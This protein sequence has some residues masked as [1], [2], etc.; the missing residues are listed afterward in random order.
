M[1]IGGFLGIYI[2]GKET[3][4]Y[5]VELMLPIIIGVIGGL[6]VFLMISKWS[7][8]RRGNVPEIDERTL[9]NLQ[10]YFLGALYFILIGSGAALLIAYAMGVKT[11]ET[12]LLILCL[13]GVFLM[14]IAGAF[15]VKRV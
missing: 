4:N 13:G 2:I 3:G 14:T 5:P 10:K 9:K 11:I 12:G 1:I 7:Q 15:I 6:M 8:K